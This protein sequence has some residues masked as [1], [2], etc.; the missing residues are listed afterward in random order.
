MSKKIIIYGIAFGSAAGA[1]LFLYL[2]KALYAS[3]TFVGMVFSPLVFG[4]CVIVAS[5]MLV[6]SINKSAE[7]KPSIAQLAFLGLI[8]GTVI[9]L[10]VTVIHKYVVTAYP[11]MVNNYLDYMSGKFQEGGNIREMPQAEIDQQ[12]E[13][14]RGKFVSSLDYF[15]SSFSISSSLALLTSAL[16][17]YFLSKRK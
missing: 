6:L 2:S 12:I 17:G 8:L 9:T 3:G 16:T 1:S 5:G 14:F 11:G 15:L 10:V 7:K 13:G 4:I